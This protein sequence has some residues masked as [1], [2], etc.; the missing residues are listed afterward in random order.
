MYNE[1]TTKEQRDDTNNNDNN[2][3][4]ISSSNNACTREKITPGKFY[5]DNI[6]M[7]T[8]TIRESIESYSNTGI[9]DDVIIKAMEES[10]KSGARNMRYAE[11]ILDRCMNKSINTLDQYE[12]EALEYQRKKEEQTKSKSKAGGSI[13]DKKLKE[14]EGEND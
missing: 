8:Q 6:G 12:A 11:K 2:D 5:Q 10:V 3:N 4:N 14:V 13:L 7:I 1:K 9:S